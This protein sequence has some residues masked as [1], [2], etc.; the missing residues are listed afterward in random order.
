MFA[1]I[2]FPG[3]RFSYSRWHATLI[4]SSEETGH[5]LERQIHYLWGRE[6]FSPV[7]SC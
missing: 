5:L 3:I 1:E 4:E 2:V 7:N 6:D